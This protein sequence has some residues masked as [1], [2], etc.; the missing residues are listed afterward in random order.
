MPHK[1]DAWTQKNPAFCELDAGLCPAPDGM[2]HKACC[3]MKSPLRSGVA[4]SGEVS[5]HPLVLATRP[6]P[7]EVGPGDPFPRLG[8]AWRDVERVADGSGRLTVRRSKTEPAGDGQTVALTVLT[9]RFLGRYAR[10]RGVREDGRVFGLSGEQLSRRLARLCEEAGLGGG[11]S[12]HSG[13][14]GLA[15][16]MTSKGAPTAAVQLQGRWKE[17]R[18]VARYV[19]REEAASAL[20][21]L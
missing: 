15:R 4:V 1:G 2:M 16:R 8:R 10:L 11:F 12:G 5:K 18:M 9:V 20:R 14:V 13:R 19:R 6:M 3:A 17:P 21:W 7:T